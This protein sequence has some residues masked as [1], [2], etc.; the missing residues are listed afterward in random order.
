ME[1]EQV[2]LPEWLYQPTAVELAE[3][4]QARKV[5]EARDKRMC[6]MKAPRV[7]FPSWDP[8]C[9]E[10]DGQPVPAKEGL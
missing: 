1:K 2:K 3:H 5:I 9:E 8:S 4:E 6:A 7:P 10:L